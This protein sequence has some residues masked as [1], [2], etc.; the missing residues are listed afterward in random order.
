M[1][2]TCSRATLFARLTQCAASAACST[3]KC[4]FASINQSLPPT[5]N[6]FCTFMRQ[7]KI[8]IKVFYAIFF[9]AF[10][11]NS[12]FLL[13]NVICTIDKKTNEK[14]DMRFVKQND[15]LILRFRS[16][17]RFA[18]SSSR[19]SSRWDASRYETNAARLVANKGR[20]IKRRQWLVGE[21]NATLKPLELLTQSFKA[22][23]SRRS[24][25]LMASKWSGQ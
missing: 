10:V 1:R 11:R 16:P 2:A 8:Q 21:N 7:Q 5:T 22:A 13:Q 24:H 12:K 19:F 23:L 17:S 4:S 9:L 14:K 18:L 3:A 25:L 20:F 15:K 6:A